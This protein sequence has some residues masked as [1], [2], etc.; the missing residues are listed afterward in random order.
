MVRNYKGREE[1]K[2]IKL[3]K[4]LLDIFDVQYYPYTIIEADIEKPQINHCYSL[5]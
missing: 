2:M 1:E 3:F 5:H 4:K